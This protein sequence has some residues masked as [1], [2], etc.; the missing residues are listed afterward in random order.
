MINITNTHIPRSLDDVHAYYTTN[1][2]SIIENI[3]IPDVFEYD[4]HA[5]VSIKSIITHML[6]LQ[7]LVPILKS[8]SF[9]T[10]SVDNTSLLRIPKTTKNLQEVN[11]TC[12]ER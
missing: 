6:A 10:L 2:Y 9:R 5:F 11:E 7:H 8:S 3:P 4:I 1:K 12:R